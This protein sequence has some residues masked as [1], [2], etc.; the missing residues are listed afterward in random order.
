[1]VGADLTQARYVDQYRL[2]SKVDLSAVDDSK[3]VFYNTSGL[4]LKNSLSNAARPASLLH[5]Q[6]ANRTRAAQK[7][8]QNALRNF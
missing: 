1:M 5:M 8:A 3:K 4:Q 7:P 6:W 2:P